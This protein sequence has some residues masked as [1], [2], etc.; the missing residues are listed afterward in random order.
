MGDITNLNLCNRLK[1]NLTWAIWKI[2][3][4][5][6]YKGITKVLCNRLRCVLPDVI[7]E[8][9][10]ALVHG[11]Y[12]IHNV[13]VCQYIVRC[14]GRKTVDPSC[15]MKL[16]IRNA[17]NTIDWNFLLE[18]MEGLPKESGNCCYYC[19]SEHCVVG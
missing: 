6:L 5:V 7:A 3:C 11:R 19:L 1:E 4:N 18:M 8:N 14:Y 16:D 2:C 15:L 10:G 17:Y 9:Q 13:I 12:I